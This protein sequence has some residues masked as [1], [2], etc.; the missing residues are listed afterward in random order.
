MP[1]IGDDALAAFGL[2]WPAIAA[3]QATAMAAA[4]AQEFLDLAD[5]HQTREAEPSWATPNEIVLELAAV[6]LR[7]F[8]KTAELS[9]ILI[10]APFALHGAILTDLAPG[11]SLVAA[12]EGATCGSLFVTDWRPASTDMS[13]RSIDDYLADL[14]VLIDAIGTPIDLIGLC[15]GGWMSLLYAARF[16]HKVHKLVLA[17]AP[18]NTAV[19]DSDLSQRARSTPL[20]VF[21]QLVALGGGRMVGRRLFRLWEQNA[22]DAEAI[23]AILQSADAIDSD[24]FRQLAARFRAWYAW[25]LDLPGRYYLEVVE[26]L[27]LKNELA[28]GG[29]I[30]LGQPIDL[31][32][33][34]LPTYLLAARDDHV[35]APAQTFDLSRLIGPKANTQH[36]LAAGGH[37]G[38]FMGR[39]TIAN[40]WREI[41][42]W[43]SEPAFP[44]AA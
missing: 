34:C 29:F 15:Q 43:L 35:V 44:R 23:R 7:R 19:G 28:T 20:A 26:R 3:E 12:M 2:L 22:F 13:S 31:A 42:R 16:P 5:D 25:T 37:L 33:M 8:R 17:G 36:A 1:G 21:R 18:I 9:P 24:A 11:Y 30:A 38:L 14:N 6:R 27:Y 40:E 4:V 10:C 41:G 39:Q 32:A